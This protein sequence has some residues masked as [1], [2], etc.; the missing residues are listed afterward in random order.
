MTRHSGGGTTLISP[1]GGA[2]LLAEIERRTR[3][4]DR[5]SHQASAI[6]ETLKALVLTQRTQIVELEHNNRLL[7]KWLFGQSSERKA[8]VASQPLGP[9]QGHLFFPE[10]MEACERVAEEHGAMG[11]VEITPPAKRRAQKGRRKQ[12]P[13]HL[14]CVRSTFELPEDKRQC[15]GQTM[16]EMGEDVTRELERIETSVFHEIARKK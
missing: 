16:E 3:I 10:I 11:S 14:P 12:F 1:D 13:D 5:A 2:V 7:T 6:T 15:C 9:G 4:V 8:A